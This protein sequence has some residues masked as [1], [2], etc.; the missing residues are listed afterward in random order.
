MRIV[1]M[2]SP[3]FAVPALEALHAS[4]HEI[5]AVVSGA[6]K[7]RGRGNDLM[8]TPVKAKAMEL[9]LP[10][11]DWEIIRASRHQGI[12]ASE[13]K[14]REARGIEHRALDIGHRTLG[15]PECDLF[16]VVAFKILPDWLLAWPRLGSVNIHASLLPLYRGA[17]PIH[18]AVMDGV[19]RTGCTIFF[20]DKGIDTGG[21]IMQEAVDVGPDETTGDV[22]ERL[23]MLGA[24]MI[25]RAAD[26]IERGEAHPAPQDGS[27]ATAA[28]KIFEGDRIIDFDRESLVVHNHVRGMSPFPCAFTTLDGMRFRIYRT[29]NAPEVSGKVGEIVDLGE[30]YFAGCRTGSVEL[31][32]VQLEGKRRMMAGDFFKGYRGEKIIGHWTSDIGH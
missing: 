9:G 29:R 16:V 6:D 22:Y 19:D 25:V 11:V 2:G 4:H 18:R 23:R 14:R 30:R 10:V 21:V 8:P 15:I 27:V 7:R 13:N 5:V 12:R 3:E 24:G 31:V 17:A 26:Q 1:F 28:P 32:D 20:L